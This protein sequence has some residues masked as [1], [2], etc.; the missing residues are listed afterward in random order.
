MIKSF[1]GENIKTPSFH[2]SPFTWLF[3]FYS[4]GILIQEFGFESKGILSFVLILGLFIFFIYALKRNYKERNP[5]PLFV[6]FILFF[7]LGQ[8]QLALTKNEFISEPP[9]AINHEKNTVLQI[10]EI[11]L[12]DSIHAKAIGSVLVKNGKNWE[13]TSQKIL[14][15]IQG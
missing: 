15:Y 4:L 10:N 3:S 12:K 5:I 11:E 6:I 1:L 2:S 7:S 13:L 9:D 8:V 14:L